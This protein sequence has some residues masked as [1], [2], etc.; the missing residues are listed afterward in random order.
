M[1]FL[2][3]KPVI[4]TKRNVDKHNNPISVKQVETKQV[5]DIHNSIPLNYSIDRNHPIVI[6]G[7][8]QTYNKDRITENTFYADYDQGI[9]Y[10]H[11]TKV[12]KSLTIVY[13]G[14]GYILVSSDRIYR[15]NT[16]D[17]SLVNESIEAT[18]TKLEN[19][20]NTIIQ[21]GGGCDQIVAEVVDA[22]TDAQGNKHNTLSNR[23]NSID[24]KINTL[25]AMVKYSRTETLGIDGNTVNVGINEYNPNNDILNVYLSGHKIIEGIHYDLDKD[26]RLIRN[27]MGTWIVGEQIHFEVY[28]R[29][30]DRQMLPDTPITSMNAN[31]VTVAPNVLGRDNVQ[32]VLIEM[33]VVLRNVPNKNDYV[34]KA[35]D[36][37]T[38]DLN[39]GTNK[40]IGNLE[41]NASTSDKLKNKVKINDTDFDGSA[42]ITTAKWGLERDIKIGNATQRVNGSANVEFRLADIG[43]AETN[44]THSANDIIETNDKKFVS[45]VEKQNWNGKETTTGSQQKADKALTD[46]KAY[47][48]TEIAG[49]VNAA[50]DTLDTLKELAD[51]LDNNPN[52]STTVL[53]QIG[54]KADRT[55]VD[56]ELQQ[57]GLELAD[58]ADLNHTH[59]SSQVNAMTGYQKPTGVVT[60]ISQT[61]NLNQAIGKLERALDDKQASGNYLPTTGGNMTGIINTNSYI[62]F[63]ANDVGIQHGGTKILRNNGTATV[64]SSINDTIYFRPGGDSSQTNQV[65]IATN[66]DVTATRFVGSLQGNATSSTSAIND[67]EGQKISTTYIKNLEVNGQ[68]ITFT[69]GDNTTGKITTQDNDTHHEAKNVVGTSNT[70]TNN[71]IT[72]NAN[73]YLNLVENNQVRSSHKITGSGA[74]TVTSDANGNITISS[75]NTNTT[76]TAGTGLTLDGTVFNHRNN[77]VADTAKGDNDKIL[78]WGGRFT[79]PTVTYDTEG[80]VTGKGVTTMTMPTNPTANIRVELEKTKSSITLSANQLQSIPIGSTLQTGEILDVF[81]SGIKIEEGVNYNLNGNRNAIVPVA[82]NVF[83]VGDYITFEITRANVTI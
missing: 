36:T 23:L 45:D 20:M 74:T 8:Y 4:I 46:A 50:P 24:S 69:R 2:D 83:V 42:N 58:K 6:T 28:Q 16:T 17:G 38:G 78:D 62:N 80:H 77:V 35:G 71:A 26:N 30:I 67:S 10:F 18:F 39:M 47:T 82:G 48:D 34:A 5:V 40:V 81:L 9:L 70:S 11:P 76:Y 59:N 12:G 3:G 31:N 21:N 75:T 51:A 79:I 44:H 1:P 49:L 65:T 73:T 14:T 32:D 53:T 13:M 66:G 25:T 37:M 63:T 54:Q 57:I 68:E 55:Y 61:D 7:M 33:E 60:A 64:L 19:L 56:N 41:G 15:Y 72:G 43:V 22:R 52:F 29:M 27:K